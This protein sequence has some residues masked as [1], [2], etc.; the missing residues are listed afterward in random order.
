MTAAITVFADKGFA[1][2]TIDDVAVAAGV[3]KRTVYN[4]YGDKERL[5][6][7]ML[8]EA[9]DTA[10][11]YA[12]R[13]ETS[14][15]TQ[16]AS[17]RANEPSLEDRLV[18]VALDLARSIH[19]GPVITLRRLLIGEANRVPDL[20]VDY[21]R[22]APGLVLDRLAQTLRQLHDSGALL[23]QDPPTAAEHFAFLVIGASL[24]RALFDHNI[25]LIHAEERAESGARAFYRAYSPPTGSPP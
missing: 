23:V 15:L 4:I 9:I 20:A 12:V 22:R 25:S 5:F 10:S 18:D 6:R 21:Y 1:G 17:G 11:S 8:K 13:L 24:D 7:E 19:G 3:A 16:H 14:G 2:A